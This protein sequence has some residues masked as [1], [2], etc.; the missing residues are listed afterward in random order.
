[1]H[2]Q[3]GNNL[4]IARAIHKIVVRQS[5]IQFSTLLILYISNTIELE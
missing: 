4:G 3:Q 5:N 2:G 1:M